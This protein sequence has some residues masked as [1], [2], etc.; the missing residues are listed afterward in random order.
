MFGCFGG[1]WLQPL[2][3]GIANA[4]VLLRIHQ[5]QLIFGRSCEIHICVHCVQARCSMF[6]IFLKIVL[7]WMLQK[8]QEQVRFGA[9]SVL[10]LHKNFLYTLHEQGIFGIQSHGKH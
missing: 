6:Y 10:L 9:L 3:Q 8:G 1:A 2:F 4:R 7:S 5:L